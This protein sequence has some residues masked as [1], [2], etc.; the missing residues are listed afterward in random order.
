MDSL[1]IVE[2]LMDIESEFGVSL[3]SSAGSVFAPQSTLSDVWRALIGGQT[4][5]VPP[6]VPPVN[7]PTWLRLQRLAAERFGMPLDDVGPETKL[8]L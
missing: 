7:D 3:P 6:P 4:G 2:F 5:K 1:D 8:G